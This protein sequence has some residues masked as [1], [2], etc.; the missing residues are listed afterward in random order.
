VNVKLSDAETTQV[1]ISWCRYLVS[2]LRDTTA[3][4]WE[5]LRQTSYRRST[6]GLLLSR[7]VFINARLML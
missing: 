3:H 6:T 2:A 4:C 7:V 1:Q 5:L